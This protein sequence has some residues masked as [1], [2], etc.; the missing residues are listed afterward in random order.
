MQKA[1]TGDWREIA[2][3]R[4]FFGRI[5][6]FVYR[7]RHRQVGLRIGKLSS[8]FTGDRRWCAANSLPTRKLNIL[9]FAIMHESI[10]EDEEGHSQSQSPTSDAQSIN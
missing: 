5:N 9:R 6:G 1:Q 2:S 8:T 7:R 10:E 4:L 3:A